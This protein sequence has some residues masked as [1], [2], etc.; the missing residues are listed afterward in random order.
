MANAHSP[1]LEWLSGGQTE[2]G[3][4]AVISE[5][6]EHSLLFLEVPS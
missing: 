2:E 3:V 4:E 1:G 6:F 5:V